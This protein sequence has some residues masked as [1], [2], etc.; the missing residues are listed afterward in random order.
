MY[1]FLSGAEFIS[2]EWGLCNVFENWETFPLSPYG[3]VKKR[4]VEFL[5]KFPAVGKKAGDEVT[6]EAP[7]G[8]IKLRIVEVSR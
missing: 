2:E 5:A 8:L 4:F 3:E 1:S 6:V 7:G